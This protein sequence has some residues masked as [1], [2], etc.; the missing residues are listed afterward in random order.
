MPRW[1]GADPALTSDSDSDPK[2]TAY[3]GVDIDS[4]GLFVVA[5]G[6]TQDK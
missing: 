2:D 3:Y 5:A 4:N 6:M 1:F